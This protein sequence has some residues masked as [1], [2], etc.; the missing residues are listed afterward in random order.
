MS[1]YTQRQEIIDALASMVIE[2]A[3][4]HGFKIEID[5]IRDAVEQ[6]AKFAGIEANETEFM[7]AS[8][9]VEDEARLMGKLSEKSGEMENPQERYRL[10]AMDEGNDHYSVLDTKT[11]LYWSSEG[12]QRPDSGWASVLTRSEAARKAYELNRKLSNYIEQPQQPVSAI[13]M[14]IAEALPA[15]S[16]YEKGYKDALES[17]VLA[18]S[19]KMA[20]SLDEAVEAA[21]DAYSNNVDDPSP[22]GVNQPGA[23][24]QSVAMNQ[25]YRVLGAHPNRNFF[26]I[27]VQAS[28]GLSAFGAAAVSL[29]EADED[30]E[31]EFFAAI[32]AHIAFDFPGDGVVTLGT[33]LDPEQA[34]VFGLEA[35]ANLDYDHSPG[36]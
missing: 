31:A 1:N 23:I 30:G 14:R 16:G 7:L 11:Q 4:R 8:Q 12:W 28:N 27:E 34:D 13:T 32:P 36:M 29:K 9:K 19:P 26:A 18:L 22:I 10:S 2:Q 17:I 21:L 15:N 24:E 3:D 20:A 5:A 25:K 6:M 33:V 35:S